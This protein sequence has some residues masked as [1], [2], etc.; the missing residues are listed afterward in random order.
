VTIV[1]Y[2]AVLAAPPSGLA[3][4]QARRPLTAVPCTGG[5]II[6]DH[7]R[8]GSML[9]SVVHADAQPKDLASDTGVDDGERG[10]DVRAW[11]LFDIGNTGPVATYAPLHTPPVK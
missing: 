2:A 4:R 1:A 8:Y 9:A 6:R 7:T 3:P 10:K 5:Q 11:A